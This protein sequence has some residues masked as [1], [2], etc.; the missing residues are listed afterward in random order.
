MSYYRLIDLQRL[1]IGRGAEDKYINYCPKTNYFT[2]PCDGNHQTG[3]I[4]KRGQKGGHIMRICK[5]MDRSEFSLQ[6]HLKL[7]NANKDCLIE[8]TEEQNQYF[9]IKN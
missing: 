8:L 3:M 4:D 1:N 2:C 9:F 7:R 5:K 6:Y